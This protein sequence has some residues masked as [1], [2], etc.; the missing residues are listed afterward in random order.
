MS[1]SLMFAHVKHACP[2]TS[3]M[4]HS[5][6]RTIERMKQTQFSD[7]GAR[8]DY[9]IRSSG[10]TAASVAKLI[11]VS[12]SAV[13]QWIA[14]TTK[15]IKNDHLFALEDITGFSARWIATGQGP[16][17]TARNQAAQLLDEAPPE[18]VQQTLDFL[19]YKISTSQALMTQEQT[20]RYLKWIDRIGK[21]MQDR[22]TNDNE[23]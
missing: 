18:I 8:I 5:I 19:G 21:D 7:R 10:H 16:Q 1:E 6:R 17:R 20:A 11:A 14:G 12:R 4:H 13:S 15:D 3:S 23:D 9:A 2:V 22:K